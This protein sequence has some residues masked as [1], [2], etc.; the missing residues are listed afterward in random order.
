MS[1]RKRP[2]RLR[3]GTVVEV[4]P[5][6]SRITLPGGTVVNGAPQDTGGYRET[7]ERLGYG[8]DT[9]QL[10]KDHDPLHSLLCDWLGL[11]DSRSLRCAAG[12]EEENE[13]SRAEESAVLAVQ[14]FMR[15]AGIGLP[16]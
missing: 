1:G 14:K 4:L 7:A 11:G 9:L 16:I 6:G 15:L 13:I 5:T 8:N 3:N 12:L 2:G 10:C